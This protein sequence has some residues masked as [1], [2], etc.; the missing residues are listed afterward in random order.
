MYSLDAG[1]TDDSGPGWDRP[2]LQ[3][4]IIL[5]R[6]VHFLKLVNCLFWNF[7]FSIFGSQVTETMGSET[8]D[9][10]A[11]LYLSFQNFLYLQKQKSQK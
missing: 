2:G 5:F 8:E 3:S 9:K 10:G 6:M 7:P 1:Q 11:L 4:F